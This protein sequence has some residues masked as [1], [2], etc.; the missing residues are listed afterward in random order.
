[1]VDPLAAWWRHSV[2]IAPFLGAGSYGD[3]WGETFTV[4]AA[5]DDTARQVA[6]GDGVEVTA[7]TTVVVP[8]TVGYVRPGSKV[9]LP[10]THGSRTIH[11]VSCRVASGGGQPTPD[12]VELYLG[13]WR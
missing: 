6:D 11:V 5:I 9:T 13:K 8:V 3:E 10:A 1:M 7:T 4:G 12:H 2:V